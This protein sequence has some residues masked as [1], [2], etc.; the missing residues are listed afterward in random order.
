L[1]IADEIRSQLRICIGGPMWRLSN[2]ETVLLLSLI[3]GA[4]AWVLLA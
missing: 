2:A 3:V 1:S 4:L